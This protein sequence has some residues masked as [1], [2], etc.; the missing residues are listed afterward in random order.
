MRKNLISVNFKYI[1]ILTIAFIVVIVITSVLIG[2]VGNNKSLNKSKDLKE[3][4]SFNISKN[5][6]IKSEGYKNGIKYSSLPK[7]SKISVFISK[8]N[9]IKELNLETYV[10]GVVAGEM[11]AEFGIEALKAQAVAARTYALAHVTEEGGTPN[12]NAH[13][14]NLCDTVGS[15]VYI[16]KEEYI[17][18][19]P[20]NSGEKYWD[21]IKLAVG[22]TQGQ[23]LTYNN[24]LVM[25][26]Y[27]FAISSGKTE[28]SEDVFSNSI[29]YL[30]SVE[31]L[32]D[33]KAKKFKSINIFKYKDL[34]RIIN[35]NYSNAKA[36]SANIKKELRVIDRT[37]AG[38]VKNIKVGSITMTGSKFRTMLGL[39]SS[40]FKIKFNFTNVEVD[41][42][43]YGHDV[44]MS[45]WGADAMA[46]DGKSYIEILTHYYQGT[47]IS[48]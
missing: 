45:Q 46:K 18:S 10:T 14:A 38:S 44:G 20:K 13:G 39:R 24:S 36:T 42:S 8:E 5:S 3:N 47:V 23:V 1:M 40:N 25:D 15:Q 21:K 33:E 31:S 41:C 48:K 22:S 29:P 26:P 19:L 12:K 43:G 16:T 9:T 37:G 6:I 7:I 17:K 35:Y 32:G 11:P 28:N 30:R 34:S 27:Y 4:K 2:G